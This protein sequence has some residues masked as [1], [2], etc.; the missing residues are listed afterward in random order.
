MPSKTL[1]R[2]WRRKY[3]M[4]T[5]VRDNEGLFFNCFQA[6]IFYQ[7]I[8]HTC[9][10]ALIFK[11]VEESKKLYVKS[12]TGN[13]CQTKSLIRTSTF[14]M[15]P[16][17]AKVFPSSGK[18]YP[19]IRGFRTL[20]FV[21]PCISVFGSARTRRVASCLQTVVRNRENELQPWDLQSW[22]A[23]SG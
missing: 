15:V 19:F 18:P 22:Q 5:M 12:Q 10:P 6:I 14:W 13:R 2:W 3:D 4:I 21:G 20:H 8:H 11:A 7:A 1:P 23:G 16:V 17:G 9:V